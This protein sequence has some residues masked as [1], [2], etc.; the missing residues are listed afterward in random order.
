[1]VNVVVFIGFLVFG[2]NGEVNIWCLVNYDFQNVLVV[3]FELMV[4]MLVSF[5][6]EQVLVNCFYFNGV[7]V[8]VFV[9]IQVIKIQMVVQLVYMIR[10]GGQLKILMLVIM[11]L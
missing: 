3:R 11:V 4:G 5:R 1:M 6:M 9:D 7:M 2:G 8:L 10:V